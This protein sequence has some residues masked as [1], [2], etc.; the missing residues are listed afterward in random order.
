LIAESAGE[1]AA[2]RLLEDL[3]QALFSSFFQQ[4]KRGLFFS[5]FKK[6]RK[7]TGFYQSF[8]DYLTINVI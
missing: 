6:S 8:L 1:D 5:L 4:G 7:K 2:C 3:P